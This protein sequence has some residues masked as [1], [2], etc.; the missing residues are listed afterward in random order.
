[1]RARVP[2]DDDSHGG[3]PGRPW[4]RPFQPVI[5]PR[6]EPHQMSKGHFAGKG[7]PRTISELKLEQCCREYGIECRRIRESMVPGHQRPDYWIKVGQRWWI[8]EVKEI[9]EKAEDRALLED[10]LSG[11][12]QAH[13]M[14][15]PLGKRLRQSIKDAASQLRKF[16]HLGFPTVVCF[17][18]RT[19][20]FYLEHFHVEQ[21]MFGQET[22]TFEV[23]ADPQHQPRFLGR[24]FGKKATLTRNNNTSISA[25]AAL[26]QTADSKLEIEIYHNPHARVPI[27]DDVTTF[28]VPR[29]VGRPES[30][31]FDFRMSTDRQVWFENSKEKCDQEIEKCLRDLRA[32]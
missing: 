32:G 19:I 24:R 20:G 7:E 6:C 18:D 30:S 17:F 22:L 3:I 29:H 21:A 25:V 23:S 12:P 31:I 8:V 2:P 11:R 28:F 9:A 10:I 15:Q 4:G 13:W 26:R 27:R 16:S 5:S 1:M 14:E